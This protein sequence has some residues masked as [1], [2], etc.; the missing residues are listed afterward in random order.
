MFFFINEISI[1]MA[2]EESSFI[3]LIA[4]LNLPIVENACGRELDQGT[5]ILG[6]FQLICYCFNAVVELLYFIAVQSTVIKC[7]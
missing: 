3:D 4:K 7:T 2:S 6:W 5:L 1:S